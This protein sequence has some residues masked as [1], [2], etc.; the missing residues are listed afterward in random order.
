[1]KKGVDERIDKGVFRWFNHV[2]RMEND[3]I[4]KRVYIR[5]CAGSCSVS[6]SQKRCI[7]T[8]KD[9]LDVR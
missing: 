5:K 8:V 6:R 7:Y 1:M 4:A 3:K 2:E 9:S